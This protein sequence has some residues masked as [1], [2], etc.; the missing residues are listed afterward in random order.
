MS[1]TPGVS[2]PSAPDLAI[3]IVNWNTPDYLAACLESVATDL[4]T[5]PYGLVETYVVDNASADHS[6]NLVREQFPWVRLIENDTNVGFAR[7]NN[8][9]AQIAT[10]RYVLLLNSDTELHPGALQTMVTF[11][12]EHPEAGAVGA[13][14]LNSDGSLQESAHPAPTLG[15]E[16]WYLCHLDKLHPLAIYPMDTWP[17]DQSRKVEILKGACL[18]FRQVVLDEVGLLDEDYFMYSEEVD[19][20]KRVMQ[21]GWGLYWEPRAVVVHHGGRSTE[22]V[23]FSMFMHLY[24]GKIMYFRKRHGRVT[25]ALY[26]L[27]LAFAIVLRLLAAPISIIERPPQRD[28]HQEMARR[29]YHLLTVLPTL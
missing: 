26:K 6:V 5:W 25:A 16:L 20:C 8:Q 13:R 27:V 1:S 17:T 18:M 2:E 10:G 7:A 23:A 4:A 14:L 19:L 9:A 11:L 12:E 3:I 22:K 24:K 21:A 15:R 28:Y 29:Y